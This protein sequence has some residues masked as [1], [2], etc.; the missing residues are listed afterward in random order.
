[1]PSKTGIGLAVLSAAAFSTSG[2]FAR[3]LIDAGWTPGA[4]VAARVSVA[5]LLLIVPGIVALRGRWRALSRRP[6]MLATYGVVAVA[7]SQLCYF[8]AVQHLA[9]GVALL[10]EYMG[11][12][13]VVGWMWTRHGHRPRRLTGAGSVV[14][15]LGLVLVL[16]PAHDARLDLAGVLWGFGAAVGLAVFFVLSAKVGEELPPLVAAAAGMTVG[17]VTLLVLGAVGAVPLHA[18]FG[19]VDLAGRQVSWLV[20]VIGLSLLAAVVPYVAGIAAAR[21]LGP[22][23]ASFVGLTEVVFAVIVAWLLLGELPT[24]M[25]IVGGV[26]IVAGVVL[27]HMDEMRGPTLPAESAESGSRAVLE[28]VPCA[29]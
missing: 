20:P 8:H 18:T 7:G 22:K 27:V 28:G 12:V 24:A 6:A 15:L 3:S 5:A 9:V 25:Q 23:L 13:L 10:I 1:M 26:L 11:V 4:A 21:A 17:A 2:S 16:N 29:S 14:A 19:V